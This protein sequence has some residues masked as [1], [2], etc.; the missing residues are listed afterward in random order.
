[1]GGNGSGKSTLAKILTGLYSPTRGRILLDARPVTNANQDLYRSLFAAV[2]TDF[3]LFNRVIGPGKEAASR[4]LAEEY[5]AR[6][7]LAGK[8]Q[9]NGKSYST[10]T[11]LSQGQRKR[12]ALLCAYLEDRPIY[13]LDEWA[14][15][16]DPPFKKFFYEVL[17][18]D[19]KS[20]GKCVIII[21]HDD[22]YFELADR[23]IKLIDGRIVSDVTLR[24]TH[25]KTAC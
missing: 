9:I 16:Q 19:L 14:A 17:L 2:F 23:I 12:L 24:S 13:V 18:T 7:G 21:T 22:Q 4:L 8:V 15:D 11:A 1:V 6:L 25:F 20:R 10:V 5:L 3:H